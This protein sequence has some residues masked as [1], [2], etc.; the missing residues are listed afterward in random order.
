MSSE[1]QTQKVSSWKDIKTGYTL[2]RL[3]YLAMAAI[4]YRHPQ[5]LSEAEKIR[6]DFFAI[7]YLLKP[8]VTEWI[9][10]T[11][12]NSNIVIYDSLRHQRR[13]N[14]M[15]RFIVVYCKD[16]CNLQRRLYV[17][18][19]LESKGEVSYIK[20]KIYF[21]GF[22]KDLWAYDENGFLYTYD[23]EQFQMMSKDLYK[24]W[25]SLV[26]RETRQVR[27]YTIQNTKKKTSKREIY[28]QQ[29]VKKDS[30]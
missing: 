25:E 13:Q 5:S 20:R 18:N 9:V 6:R 11:N 29:Y 3:P 19:K 21:W 27:K 22:D 1:V 17:R 12:E 28:G 8:E 10:T 4:S 23:F 2:Y 26:K 14:D 24:A 16:D 7:S 15:Q 30:K